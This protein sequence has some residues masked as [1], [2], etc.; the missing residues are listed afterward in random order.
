MLQVTQL[1]LETWVGQFVWPFFRVLALIMAAPVYSQNSISVRTKVGLAAAIALVLAPTLPPAAIPLG[2]A[3]AWLAVAEQMLA[4]FI[5]GFSL[6]I[7]FGA[8]DLA[9]D[10]LGLQMGIGFATFIDPQN[11]TQTPLVGSL[12]SLLAT[13]LF[14]A[15]DGHLLVLDALVGS[16]QLIPVGSMTGAGANA[17]LAT[18]A[19]WEHFARLGTHLFALGLQISLP[20]L[21]TMLLC[22]LTLGVMARPAPQLNLFSVGFPVTVLTGLGVLILFLPGLAA[23]LGTAILQALQLWR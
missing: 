4:G 10:M 22:N 6:Q 2:S 18:F 8:L 19:N 1:Q 3:A 5:I 7:V 12:L 9:G 14:L 20:L 23:P 21:A 17:G 15:I 16:F 13:L 11:S